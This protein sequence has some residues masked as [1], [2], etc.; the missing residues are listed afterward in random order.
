MRG[1]SHTISA[2]LIRYR[3]RMY[4]MESRAGKGNQKK[5]KHMNLYDVECIR[6][7]AGV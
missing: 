5:I 7:A 1:D 3:K 2:S 6:G 4:N